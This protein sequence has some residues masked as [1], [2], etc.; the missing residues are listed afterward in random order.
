MR[1]DYFVSTWRCLLCP[2]WAIRL[3]NAHPKTRKF[4]HFVGPLLVLCGWMIAAA[5]FHH[6]RSLHTWQILLQHTNCIWHLT[7]YVFF[8]RAFA[9]SFDMWPQTFAEFPVSPLPGNGWF[10]WLALPLV[11]STWHGG[12][13]RYRPQSFRRLFRFDGSTACGR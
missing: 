10:S 2:H 7:F 8:S 4:N 9:N 13:Q 12:V 5:R 6:P 1:V 11:Q 3:S